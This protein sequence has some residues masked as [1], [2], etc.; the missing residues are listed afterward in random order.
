MKTTGPRGNGERDHVA[1]T[2]IPDLLDL[3]F[4]HRLPVIQGFLKTRGQPYS[5]TW[6]KVRERIEGCI[7]GK[8]I[9]GD[10]LVD[11]LDQISGWGNQQI[12]LYRSPAT[13]IERWN[14]EAKARGVLRARN[15]EELFNR[16][17][18]LVLPANPCLSAVHWTPRGVRF[19]WIEKRT[20]RERVPEEDYKSDD[21]EF[22]A[23]RVHHARGLIAFDWD[24]ISG[25]AAL[26]IQR[27]P[28]GENYRD[29]KTRFEAELE[30]LVKISKFSA[31]YVSPAILRVEKSGEVRHRKLEYATE[32]GAKISFLSR[33]RRASTFDDPA[34]KKARQELGDRLAGQH[35]NFYWPMPD[36]TERE[37]HVKLLA[38]DQRLAIFG[39]CSE[40]E[41]R[42]VLGRIRHHCG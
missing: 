27:L 12:Y 2:D 33:H 5:G 30:S 15:K 23:H 10:E 22:T 31:V 13:L 18:P 37:I 24:F 28:S 42:H 36:H 7:D 20:W 26:L 32:R 29:V 25:H 6:K 19:I 39:E 17:L 9:R 35:G 8:K 40:Q 16:R 11:L 4:K 14:T 38:K 41:V 1:S 3:L 34:L 21:I